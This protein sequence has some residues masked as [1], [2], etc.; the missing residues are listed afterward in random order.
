ML[1]AS[2]RALSPARSVSMDAQMK[3]YSMLSKASSRRCR[4]I[5]CWR[6]M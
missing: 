3:R 6:Q 5:S 1:L 2:T 4:K